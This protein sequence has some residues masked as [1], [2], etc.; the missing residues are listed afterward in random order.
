MCGAQGVFVLGVMGQ[1]G[2]N[3]GEVAEVGFDFITPFGD[4]VFD[5]V[6]LEIF[7]F[8]ERLIGLVGGVTVSG[9]NREEGGIAIKRVLLGG[10]GS[11]D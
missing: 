3:A 6:Q 7:Y 9:N 8:W 10:E 4:P 5:A 1:D 2:I 11:E